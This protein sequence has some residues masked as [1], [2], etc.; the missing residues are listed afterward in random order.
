MITFEF[1]SSVHCSDG[2]CKVDPHTTPQIVQ[3]TRPQMVARF[4]DRSQMRSETDSVIPSDAATEELSMPAEKANT[5]CFSARYYHTTTQVV[6]LFL[7]S[8][9]QRNSIIAETNL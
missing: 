7:S 3:A 5:A 6:F 1:K 9:A 8:R 4:R 2:C